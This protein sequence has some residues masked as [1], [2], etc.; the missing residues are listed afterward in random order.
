MPEYVLI[1]SQ[2]YAVAEQSASFSGAS[3]DGVA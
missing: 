2:Q 1:P 3:F